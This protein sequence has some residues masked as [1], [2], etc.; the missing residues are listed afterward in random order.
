MSKRL[1]SMRT[2]L[3]RYIIGLA[4][5]ASIIF[6][7]GMIEY[8]ESGLNK[9]SYASILMDV[10]TYDQRYRV[11]PDTPLPNS[12]STQMYLDN[13]ED[14]SEFYQKAVPFAELEPNKFREIEWKPNGHHEWDNAHFLITYLHILPDNRKLYVVLDFDVGLFTQEERD[15]FDRHFHR[16]FLFSCAYFVITLLIVFF[17]NRRINRHTQSLAKWAEE[18][19]PKI[20]TSHT[21][22]SATQS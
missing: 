20:W 3:S 4:L 21:L 13:W 17:Y 6:T 18:I 2:E 16:V 19:T 14:A 15:D 8:F 11:N 10:R 12:Y 22:T 7:S 5:V 9:A 1:R